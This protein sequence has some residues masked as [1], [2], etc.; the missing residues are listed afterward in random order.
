MTQVSN[1]KRHG[2]G[3]GH[4]G[5][6]RNHVHRVYAVHMAHDD[7]VNIPHHPVLAHGARAA[8]AALLAGLEQQLDPAGQL[9]ADGIQ[10]LGR[11]DQHGGMG[12]MAAG[13][14]HTVVSGAVGLP[15]IVFQNGQRVHIAPDADGKA[16][17]LGVD[18]D[19]DGVPAIFV[20]FIAGHLLN[21]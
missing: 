5:I 20:R 2:G 9:I 13:V 11:A 16:G 10:G 1:G 12:I 14:H 3:V 6:G 18:R 4:A 15:V 19:H 21:H 7:A 17:N 8:G